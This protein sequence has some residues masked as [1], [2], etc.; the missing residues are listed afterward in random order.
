MTL[1][2]KARTIFEGEDNLDIM[3]GINS[4]SIDLVYLDSLFNPRESNLKD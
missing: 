1:N 4:V 3:R 2:I